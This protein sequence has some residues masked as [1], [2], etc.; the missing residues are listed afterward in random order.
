[1]DS[2]NTNLPRHPYIKPGQSR[3]TRQRRQYNNSIY[4][5]DKMGRFK[6]AD[7][8]T[9]D[10]TLNSLIKQYKI[11]KSKR[12]KKELEKKI[13]ILKKIKEDKIK[14]LPLKKRMKYKFDRLFRNKTRKTNIIGN[15]R[16]TMTQR[17]AR[18]LRSLTQAQSVTIV[19]NRQTLTI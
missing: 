18:S 4:N 12:R 15:N 13:K 17:L 7:L 6:N 5:K 19:P 11:S 2:Q 10:I 3:R 1:M 8:D 14:S 16:N 9:I